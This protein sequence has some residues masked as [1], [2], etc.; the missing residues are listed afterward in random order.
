VPIRSFS[1]VGR[2]RLVIGQ[3]LEVSGR[4][5]KFAQLIRKAA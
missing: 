2:V 3:S 5:G 1:S 4:K